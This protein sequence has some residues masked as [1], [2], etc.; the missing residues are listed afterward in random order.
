MDADYILGMVCDVVGEGEKSVERDAQHPGGLV[1]REIGACEGND[2]VEAGLVGVGEEK[3]DRRHR[4]GEQQALL[5][6]PGNDIR[7]T[8]GQGV[9]RQLLLLLPLTSSPLRE[10]GSRRGAG[11]G[12][13][14]RKGRGC[15]EVCH[16]DRPPQKVPF[17]HPSRW[18]NM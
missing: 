10:R 11:K 17:H 2:G 14:R 12:K 8:S 4:G 5:L 15:Q 7:G 3:G 1:G 13:Q 9:R 6:H 16:R 18:I